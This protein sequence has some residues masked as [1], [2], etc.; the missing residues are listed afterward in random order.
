MWCLYAEEIFNSY[1]G[2]LEFI[3]DSKWFFFF[4]G[5][6][7]FSSKHNN[8]VLLKYPLR[9][10]GREESLETVDLVQPLFESPL[11]HKEQSVT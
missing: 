9:K 3:L 10:N 7:I 11:E 8:Y 4:E 1:L 5:G 6:G 2:K